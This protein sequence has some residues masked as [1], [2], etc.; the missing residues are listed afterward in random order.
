MSADYD[1]DPSVDWSSFMRRLAA[2]PTE[3]NITRKLSATELADFAAMASRIPV[4][5]HLK[6]SEAGLTAESM[7]IIGPAIVRLSPTHLDLS[8]NKLTPSGMAALS[9]FLSQLAQSGRLQ[10]LILNECEI[11]DDGLRTLFGALGRCA[12]L[13]TLSLKGIPFM[14][15][16]D[17]RILLR[18]SQWWWTPAAADILTAELRNLPNLERLWVQDNNISQQESKIKEVAQRYNKKL[19]DMSAIMNVVSDDNGEPCA[20]A[21]FLD[22]SLG[23]RR[24]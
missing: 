9:P 2:G 14:T 5:H 17:G 6:L 22:P 20:F 18:R 3:I 23:S 19:N 21:Q 15:K 1:N 16:V 4:V 24:S 10:V 7:P 11:G 12:T 13:T 8:G